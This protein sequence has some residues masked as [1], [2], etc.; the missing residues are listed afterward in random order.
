MKKNIKRYLSYVLGVILAMGLGLSYA[1]AVG[2]ND[3]NAFVTTTE[4]ETKVA[5]IEASLDNVTKTIND[6]N[7][8]FML[9]GPRLQVSLI[10]GYEKVGGFLTPTSVTSGCYHWPSLVDFDHTQTQYN[11]IYLID[12]YDGRQKIG[13]TY[14][15]TGSQTEGSYMLRE[16]MAFKTDAPDIYVIASICHVSHV[17]FHYVHVGTY[18]IYP[19]Q[20]SIPVRTLTFK[21]PRSEWK[22]YNNSIGTP[23]AISRTNSNVYYGYNRLRDL[24]YGATSNASTG[25]TQDGITSTG[26]AYITK[27]VDADYI[28]YVLQF[29]TQNNVIRWVGTSDAWDIMP[30]LTDGRKVGGAGDRVN[31]DLTAT[32]G[33]SVAKVY[34]PIKGCWCLKTFMN[35]EIPIM[36]E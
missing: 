35:G 20:A 18:P 32:W 5:Q 31:I 27:T 1:Y 30:V 3:S 4:W 22:R 12:T 29:P 34:S 8:D 26:A 14:W 9:N 23:V 21:L 6:T 10:D 24:E 25:A 7:M 19:N 28:T 13:V 17:Y 2:A 11:D 16:K 33:G 36:N 15:P